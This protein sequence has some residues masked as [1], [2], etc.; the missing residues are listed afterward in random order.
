MHRN[1]ADRIVAYVVFAFALVLYVLTVAPTAL[2]WDTGEFIAIANKLEVS[3]PPGAPFYMLVGRLFSMFVPAQGVALAVNMISVLASAFTVMLTHLIIVR[4]VREWQRQQPGSE[5]VEDRITAL[6]GGVIGA[7]TLAVSD[8]FWFNAVEAEVYGLSMCFTAIVVWLIMKWSE[9]IRIEEADLPGRRRLHGGRHPHGLYSHRYLVLIA[10][11]F[12]L[13][14]GVHLLNLL[15]IAFIALIFFFTEIEDPSWNAGKRW[16]GLLLTGIIS[17]TVF[18]IIY[19]GVVQYLPA[20][21][22]A[23]G[24]PV[25]MM[26][27]LVGIIALGIHFTQRKGWATG[28]L[29]LLCIAVVLIGYSTYALIFIR[30]AANPPIDENDPETTEAIVSYLKREQYGNIPLLKGHSF[31]DRMQRIDFDRERFFPRRHSPEPNHMRA[32]AQYESDW[33]FFWRYQI[34]HMYVRYFLWQ[35]M[36]R[37][38]D[39][40]EAPPATGI[41]FIDD[42]IGANE[43][44]PAHLQTPSERESRNVYYALPLLLG[45]IGAGFHFSRDWRR[46]LSVLA[47]FLVTGIGIIVYINQTP[48]QPRE[49]DYAYVAS[50]FAFSIWIGLGA[51]GILQLVRESLRESL[52][53]STRKAILLMLAGLLFVAVPAWMMQENYFD[54]DRSGNYAAEDFGYNM[55]V[56][57][58]DDAILF[59]NGDNDTFPLWY[60]QEIESVRRDVRVV[61][62]SLLNTSWY[63]RQ[64]KHQWARDSAPLP[65]S[66]SDENIRDISVTPWKPRSIE[67]PVDTDRF[68]A[69][70]GTP[71]RSDASPP[72]STPSTP[73]DEMESGEPPPQVDTSL[74]ANPM[75]W[76]LEG[77]PYNDEYHLLHAADQVSLNILATNARQA[78]ERPVYFAVTVSTRGQLDLQSYFQLEGMS[79]QVV[80]VRHEENLGR[81]DPVTTPEGLMKFR[82]RNLDD[83]G[84]YYD[85]T[86]RSL[87]DNYRNIYAHAAYALASEGYREKSTMLLDYLM[88]HVPF[89]TIPGDEQSFLVL[90]QA[91]HEAGENDRALEII[92][93]VEPILLYKLEHAR[94]NRE[95]NRA[96]QYIQVVRSTYLEL[97]AFQAAS[98]LSSRIAEITNDSSYRRS[99]EEIERLFEDARDAQDVEASR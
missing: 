85:E 39:L 16:K 14:I 32:Y 19:P 71:P 33:D 46:A 15:A 63:T 4:I 58:E 18:L 61:N 23:S 40:R 35:F 41:G 27:A 22:G 60:V 96:A 82:F 48:Y 72:L 11:L 64:L 52:T 31:D 79:F 50:F 68:E 89:E 38:S 57:L 86:A 5:T 43:A 73:S 51:T 77:R 53:G 30:S 76:H 45:L 13:A 97:R 80:P 91:W 88:K 93:A 21:A 69:A 49:R 25:L 92:Q 66:L 28:N 99:A 54:H 59:T 70:I 26:F 20:I 55:L 94:T 36:G 47:L 29:V 2:F 10:Y 75:R 3:H 12:G 81:V 7:L 34:G 83:P 74:I 87:M 90:A 65:I 44:L 1:R 84:I 6:S 78:W 56:G 37:S 8:S 95:L 24:S 42:R 67:L 9:Q 98:D 17:V 62:L